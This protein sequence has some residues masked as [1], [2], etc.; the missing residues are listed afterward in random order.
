VELRLLDERLGLDAFGPEVLDAA[1][2]SDTLA[3][4][5]A[6]KRVPLKPALLDQHVLAGMGNRDADESR[7][8][9]RLDPRCPASGLTHEEAARL[10]AA[11]RSV[12]REG[13]ERRGTLPDLWVRRGTHLNYR[14]IFERAGQPCPRCDGAIERIRQQGRQTFYS[15]TCQQ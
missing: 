6:K 3:A 11:M 2:T 5:L 12:L 14:Q 13:I 7:W 9:A 10:T 1:F 15:P 8:R 4:R